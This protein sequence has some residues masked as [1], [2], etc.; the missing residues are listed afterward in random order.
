MVCCE[1]A[2]IVVKEP[3]NPI[4]KKKYRFDFRSE[5]WAIAMP[6]QKHPIKLTTIVPEGSMKK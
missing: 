4:T 2:V 6:M 5:N 3:K 1:K